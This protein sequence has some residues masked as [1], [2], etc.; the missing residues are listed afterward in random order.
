MKQT[1]EWFIITSSTGQHRVNELLQ[2][3]NIGQ[4]INPLFYIKYGYKI[5]SA[6][7]KETYYILRDLSELNFKKFN[8]LICAPKID[9][10]SCVLDTSDETQKYRIKKLERYKLI[11]RI[12]KNEFYILNPP[13][14]DSTFVSTIIKLIRRKKLGELLHFYKTNNNPQ[15]RIRLLKDIRTLQKLGVHHSHI[16]MIT[17]FES[18]SNFKK[19]DIIRNTHNFPYIKK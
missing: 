15:Q 6:Q 9:Y 16:N 7:D 5:L 2:E 14:P 18:D 10:L 4:P 19:I 13:Y 8:K 3:L 17:D 1:Q 12:N 11:K